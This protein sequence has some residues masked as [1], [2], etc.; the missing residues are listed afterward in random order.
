VADTV[1]EGLTVADEL[2]AEGVGSAMSG[3]GS[4]SEH[5]PTRHV[6]SR[7]TSAQRVRIMRVHPRE[8][9]TLTRTYR[10]TPTA[11]TH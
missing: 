9:R 4:S 2:E 5:A 10:R 11:A 3:S 6:A 7:V 1:G 8:K